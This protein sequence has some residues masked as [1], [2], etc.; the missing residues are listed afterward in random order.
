MGLQLV[1]PG[2]QARASTFERWWNAQGEW[3]EE[4]NLRR[5]GE[6]GVK[7]LRLGDSRLPLLYCK[8]Q[9]GHLY[10]SLGHPFGRPTALRE[11]HALRALERLGIRVPRVV[12]CAA[13]RPQGQWRAL[14]VTEELSGFVS[15]EQWYHGTARSVGEALRHQVL[16]RLAEMLARLHRAGWQHGCLYPKHIFV[17][18]EGEGDRAQVEVALLDLEKC[19]R[20]LSCRRASRRDMAQL[21][22]HAEPMPDAD[23]FRLEAE[24]RQALAAVRESADGF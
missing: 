12:Y 17:R 19:R 20:R 21:R 4:P 6:S 18:V 11:Y 13:Q 22:R 3:V 24:Y 16:R 10:R 14:L 5:A 7:R 9:T 2:P 1:L 8:R 15:L 23:W